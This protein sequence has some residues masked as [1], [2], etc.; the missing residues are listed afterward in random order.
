MLNL[1]KLTL[2]LLVLICYN[3]NAEYHD[4][5]SN[6][7][8]NFAPSIV[9]QNRAI[10]NTNTSVSL[11]Q[12]NQFK[13][14]IKDKTIAQQALMLGASA[15]DNAFYNLKEFNYICTYDKNL[16][17]WSYFDA[18][19]HGLNKFI[20]NISKDKIKIS[21]RFEKQYSNALLDKV[22]EYYIDYSINKKK[23]SINA[24]L[25]NNEVATDQFIM[26]FNALGFNNIINNVING[27]CKV[28]SIITQN[29]N[30]HNKELS[31]TEISNNKKPFIKLN[32]PTGTCWLNSAFQLLYTTAINCNSM[33]NTI[34]DRFI[35][36]LYT[37]QEEWKKEVK[38]KD[39]KQVI[40]TEKKGGFTIQH[41]KILNDKINLISELERFEKQLGEA[42]RNEWNNKPNVISS[43]NELK[44][45]KTMQSQGNS[46]IHGI[47][48]LLNIF[49]ELKNVFSVQYS[50]NKNKIDS[51]NG[52]NIFGTYVNDGEV[53]SLNNL[54]PSNS[55][56]SVRSH[57]SQQQRS[58]TYRNLT[59]AQD[60]LK[61]E[62]VK[63]I[64]KYPNNIITKAGHYENNELCNGLKFNTTYNNY[65][66]GFDK[67]GKLLI[68]KLS[69][70]GMSKDG[71][72]SKS[73]G[74]TMYR[75]NNSWY[76]MDD[77]DPYK[78]LTQKEFNYMISKH[79]ASTLI[80][81][82]IY[83][84]TTNKINHKTNNNRIKQVKKNSK[85]VK[86]VRKKKN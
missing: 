16:N 51:S 67:D 56:H 78:K 33:S 2:P 27:T 69:S 41:Y 59:I 14:D 85:K 62:N 6:Y 71:K 9:L 17:T 38:K 49:P 65:L 79:E 10:N 4:L 26:N 32:N 44:K 7:I 52:D 58:I 74:Y 75:S 70:I 53:K 63:Y 22:A 60:T 83:C 47:K 5:S 15:I 68:Y 28:K 36:F 35:K 3:A 80:Y 48:L 54:L 40:S 1:L 64:N 11:T 13:Q 66:S 8:N 72:A 46:E 30:Q 77:N 57:I 19:R 21:N 23:D 12:F 43:K 24:L 31:E 73:H 76:V 81:N 84:E 86:I 42:E 37:R 25:N 82:Q 29:N 55:K 34:F 45:L 50:N 61:N 39:Y 20:N 18:M